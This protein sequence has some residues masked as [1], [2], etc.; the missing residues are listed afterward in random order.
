VATVT[1]QRSVDA[2]VTWGDLDTTYTA[3]T[4]FNIVPTEDCLYRV[5]VK[6]GDFTSGTISVKVRA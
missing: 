6:T 4:E 3:P 5:G 1:P 2:G